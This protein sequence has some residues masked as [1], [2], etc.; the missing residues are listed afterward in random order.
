MLCK[1]RLLGKHVTD[2]KK[3]YE[4]VVAT[5]DS[6]DMA[7]I[8]IHDG[9][10]VSYLYNKNHK[11]PEFTVVEIYEPPIKLKP[12]EIKFK[13]KPNR[14]VSIETK[15]ITEIGEKKITESTLTVYGG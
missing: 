3:L 6:H 4:A 10:G 9:L 15:K 13:E 5:Q 11:E 2:E 12:G 7:V 8:G 14:V 1:I